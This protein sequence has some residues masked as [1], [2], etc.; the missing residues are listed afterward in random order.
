MIMFPDN[1]YKVKARSID[2]L[3][4]DCIMGKRKV[5]TLAIG[6]SIDFNE[7]AKAIVIQFTMI[8]FWFLN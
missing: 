8:Y 1:Q 4:F 5:T 2:G 6:R 7:S 3:K